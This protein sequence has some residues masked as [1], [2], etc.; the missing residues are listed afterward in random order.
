M[1]RG[2]RGTPERDFHGFPAAG[3]PLERILNPNC[4]TNNV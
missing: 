4:L 3:L 2:F 1:Q